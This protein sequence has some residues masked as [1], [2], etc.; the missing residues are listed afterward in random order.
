[1]NLVAYP[2]PDTFD[3]Y[4]AVIGPNGVLHLV[5]DYGNLQCR[6]DKQPDLYTP[7]DQADDHHPRCTRCHAQ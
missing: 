7:I 5:G 1:M 2:L 4:Y 3:R 6:P